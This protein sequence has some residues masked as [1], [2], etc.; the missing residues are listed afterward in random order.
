LRNDR[1][2]FEP[3]HV[4][5]ILIPVKGTKLET[6]NRDALVAD[7][8]E[9]IR[10]T[11]G[12]EYAAQTE[13]TPLT[14]GTMQQ[15]FARADR[16][17]PEAFHPGDSIYVCGTRAGYDGAAG[18]RVLR[19]RFFTEKDFDQPNTLAVINET[20]ARTYFGGEDAVGKQILGMPVS[21]GSR[22]RDGW[23]T[24]VGVVSDSK[25]VGLDAAPG[26]Q[27]YFNGITYPAATQLQFI[28]RSVGDQKAL[29]SALRS[30][31]R[32]L[33]AEL[34]AN[35]VPLN[36]TISTM[37]GGP[38]FNAILVGSFALIALLM[39]V[40][41][42]YGVLAFGVTQRTREI[43]VRLALGGTRARVFGLVLREGMWEVAI[44]VG[45]GAA[46]VFAMTRFLKALLYG[47]SA[48]D[49]LTFISVAVGLVLAAGAAISIP[50]R[51]AARVDPMVALR[52]E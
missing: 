7:L 6:G 17:S 40:V 22:V 42:V 1:L 52:H 32:T 5:N 39:A 18:L 43:G 21:Q 26:P 11:P 9:F 34:M 50:A 24:V 30:R 49:P 41:G 44:G 12:T 16:P 14:T 3:E 47:V 31:L 13:C 23:K 45:S 48:T 10:H 46:A 8:L 27:A 2:G 37:S 33:D 29:E 35:F 28:V 20:A 15:T 51:R 38:R 25:N 4:L 19:G 36:E